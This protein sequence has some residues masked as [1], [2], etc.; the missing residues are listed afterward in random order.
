MPAY[1]TGGV[2]IMNTSQA[3]SSIADLFAAHAFRI[4]EA[5]AVRCAQEQLTY[6]EL[7]KSAGQLAGMLRSLGA[8]R[9]T[10]IAI[11][12]ERSIHLVIGLLGTL[13]TG[14][15]YV[16][17]DPEYP[18][19]RLAYMIADSAAPI[20]L[21]QSWLADKLPR[22]EAFTLLM[23]HDRPQQPGR[24]PDS[25]LQLT[26]D[27]L[28]YMIYTSGSTGKPKGAMNTHG[29]ILNRLLWMQ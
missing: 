21:T 20:L 3:F 28:A 9:G 17:L 10:L 26:A 5:I 29:G 8:Q 1:Q 24:T 27:D 25:Q 11:C 18:K 13:K 7:N 23:D 4:P 14:A 12:V 15:A 22:H 2:L 6:S 19:E 16:P